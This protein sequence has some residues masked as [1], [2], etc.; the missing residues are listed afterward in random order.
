[1]V[2]R[3]GEKRS[4]EGFEQQLRDKYNPERTWNAQNI[5][6]NSGGVFHVYMMYF[7]LSISAIPMEL[8]DHPR[9]GNG[10]NRDHQG[11]DAVSLNSRA[12]EVDSE[13]EGKF[14]IP[15]VFY[16]GILW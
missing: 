1:M 7:Y 16:V 13:R 14:T 4:L 6:L 10:I 15:L 9:W 2:G 3:I 5:D 11:Q 12:V 8:I